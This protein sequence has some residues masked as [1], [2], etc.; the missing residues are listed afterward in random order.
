MLFDVVDLGRVDSGKESTIVALLVRSLHRG[1]LDLLLLCIE[2]ADE[3]A[4]LLV[5]CPLG[6]LETFVQG[7]LPV[8][9]CAQPRLDVFL[10]VLILCRLFVAGQ[11]AR[12]AR[13]FLQIFHDAADLALAE[14]GEVFFDRLI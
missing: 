11:T 9:L 1:T 12:K 5:I 14:V 4:W 6:L 13:A 7:L 3:G 2:A 10:L 8:L